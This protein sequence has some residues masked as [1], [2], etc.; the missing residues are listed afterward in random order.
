[1][2]HEEKEKVEEETKRLGALYSIWRKW[3]SGSGKHGAVRGP[4]K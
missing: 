1:M 4:L 3:T 2:Y